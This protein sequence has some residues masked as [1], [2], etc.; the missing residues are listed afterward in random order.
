MFDPTQL[1]NSYSDY[2]GQRFNVGNYYGTPTNAG[3]GQPITGYSPYVPPAASQPT[4]GTTLN[5]NG[6]TPQQIAARVQ[7]FTA[8]LMP[9]SY[10]GPGTVPGGSPEMEAWRNQTAQAQAMGQLYAQNLSAQQGSQ[11]SGM[12][13]SASSLG[14]NPNYLMALA[15]PDKVTTPGVTG[16][17]PVY[18]PN[19]Q[20]FAAILAS[21]RAPNGGGQ[22]PAAPTAGVG[23]GSSGISWGG[24]GGNSAFLQALAGLQSAGSGS[25]GK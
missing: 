8:P 12:L 4:P 14:S 15:H 5:S 3:T 7:Q 1:S 16:I 25:G 23:G 21:L 19:P 18:Q 11:P 22:A 10:E 17:N 6:L 13:S 2:N 9:S 20:D 24:G